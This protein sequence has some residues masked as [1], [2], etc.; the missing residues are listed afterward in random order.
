M[1]RYLSV[2]L[3][4]LVA[5][6]IGWWDTRDGRCQTAYL[7]YGLTMQGCPSGT[8]RQTAT[9]EASGVR[10]GVD[11]EVSLH[12]F[13]H[14]T[15]ADAD[16]VQTLRVPAIEAVTL[17]LVDAKAVATPLAPIA[18]EGSRPWSDGL[19]KVKI[20]EV[21]DG[22]YKLHASFQTR[23]GPGELDV[24]L[25]LYTPARIHVI[26][27]R[28][29]YEPGNTVRFRAVVLRARDL[30]PLDGRPGRWVIKDPSGEVLLEEKAPAT[31]WGVVA[32]TFPL[33]KAA[34]TGTWHLAWQSADAVDDVPFTVQPFKLP[35]FRVEA[36]PDK[37]FYRPGDRPLVRGAV[38]YSSGAPVPNAKIE[39]TWTFSGEW[40]PPLDWQDKL[41]PKTAQ[42]KANG[43]FELALPEIPVD[44]AGMVTMS[45]QLAAVDPAGDRVEGSASVLL[46][47]DGIAVSSVTE[48]GD[49]LVQGFNNRMYVRVTTP[50]GQV[51]RKTKVNLKRAWQPGDPGI[52][53][54][55]DEDGVASVQLDPGAP[56]N[57]VVPPLPFRPAPKV[58][59]VTRG[60]AEDL[61]GGEGASLADQVELDKWLPPLGACAKW[62]GATTEDGEG[63]GGNAARI[64]MRIDASG[65]IATVGAAPDPL[66][67]CVAQ[68]VRGKRLPAGA[69]RLYTLTFTF[70]DPEL[71]K[72]EAGVESALDEPEVLAQAISNLAKGTRDCLPQGVEGALPKALSWRA[73]AGAKEIE[74]GPWIS[75]REGGEA[76]AALGC[77]TAR[78]GTRIAVKEPIATDSLGLIR[79]SLTPPPQATQTRPQAT[80]MLGYELAVSA[81]LPGK[82]STKLRVAPGEI[83][84][85]RLRVTPILPKAGEA[86]TVGV[87]RGPNF[88]GTLPKK[89]ELFHAKG[90]LEAELDPQNTATFT[91]DPKITGW[92][93][94]TV[95][96]TRALI[97]I[98]PDADLTVSVEPGQP[99]YKPGDEA[100]LAIQTRIGGQGGPAAVGLFGVDESLG[101]LVTLPGADSMAR[102]Q[103]KVETSAPAFGSLDG[104]ALT[105]GRIRGPN[106]AAAT[107][108]R[109]STIPTPPQLDAVVSARGNTSF[110]PVEELTDHFY[111]VLAELHVQARA[112][113]ASAPAT[114]KMRPA[115]MAR[116][117]TAALAAC[118]ARHEP[119]VD[120]YGRRLRLGLLPPDL[121]SLTDP[122]AVIVLGTRLP[123]D[124][125]N[126]AKWVAK[127]KP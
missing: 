106:A 41:L 67:Q 83:P 27:D 33:D 114:E 65:G 80:T 113:E 9:L 42:T 120:A 12:A 111:T 8:I 31:D 82:P 29:L 5:V 13:A 34:Q 116:L 109:V 58:A 49:G 86:V 47:K 127:E 19:A 101:Q 43:R 53:A 70:E 25:A 66:G 18:A 14:Y 23:L 1:N 26:T 99:R 104:Q 46:S 10:R 11:A 15:T 21:P 126:W 73:R 102:L 78:F 40:P 7:S 35:R 74:L 89:L 79:F 76:G 30:A 103:P 117:W 57:I 108:L 64:G 92:C 94:V 91:L 61:I 54:E 55:L 112:W 20:P 38:I 123:E 118:E 52:D 119:V 63:S 98:R 88:T 87:F 90:K 56:V 75:N 28:P 95:L 77:V 81:D 69:E 62:V 100:K 59:L 6:L 37:P 22:D 84:D 48:L 85:I 125:E 2:L 110:D 107:V 16:A 36:T 4:L 3:V 124:N 97:Y 44:L 71:P 122:R 93:Q 72:L 115:T 50:D 105:L 39:L 45:A 60:E 32:G 51:V 68:I 24:P 96:G 17:T 121:L